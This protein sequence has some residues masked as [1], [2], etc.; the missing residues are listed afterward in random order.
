MTLRNLGL[1]ALLPAVLAACA[2]DREQEGAREET[3]AAAARNA[4]I[5]EELLIR[6][7]TNLASLDTL[8]AASGGPRGPMRAALEYARAYH[9][10]ARLRASFLAYTDSAV[11]ARTP[12]DSTR[13]MQ[14]AEGFRLGAPEAGTLEGNVAE[15]YARNFAGTLATPAH[16]C[17]QEPLGR[18]EDEQ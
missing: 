15:E 5:G 13:Y 14:R 3:R 7:R 9:D 2:R 8:A 16:Y 17:N 18:G 4:C 1:T 10:H 6:A 12:G 11:S